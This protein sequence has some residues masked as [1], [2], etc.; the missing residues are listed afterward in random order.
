MAKR[1][2]TYE[3]AGEAGYVYVLHFAEKLGDKAVHYIGCTSDPRGRLACHASGMSSSI[4]RACAVQGVAFAL[5]AIGQTHRRGMRR[6]ERQAKAWKN[7]EAFCE[8]CNCGSAHAIPGTRSLPLDML[9]F[10]TTSDGYAGAKA[11]PVTVA[12]T[13]PRT[14]VMHVTAI[15]DLSETEKD[16]LGFIPMGGRSAGINEY[17][18][19]GNVVLA[20]QGRE[21][22]GYLLFGKGDG[23]EATIQQTVVLDRLR[24]SG[25]G[26]KMVAKVREAL[27]AHRL[28][29]RVR[30]DLDANGFWRA[31]GFVMIA[32]DTHH[33]S[34][35]A[36]NVWMFDPAAPVVTP[37]ALKLH[38]AA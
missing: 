17:I 10:P 8:L 26:R 34:G 13:S 33:T 23:R 2:T 19:S 38:D 11:K 36:L 35:S 20:T 5:G 18:E 27:P 32:V 14:P 21:L 9:P 24:G 16:A 3:R 22:V 25:I 37:P 15:R 31:I 4:M 30:D 29:A 7:A 12:L 28:Y 6:I 1:Q